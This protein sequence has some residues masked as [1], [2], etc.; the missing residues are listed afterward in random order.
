MEPP[1]WGL[2]AQGLHPSETRSHPP[3]K[4]PHAVAGAGFS[5]VPSSTGNYRKTIFSWAS[6][7]RL[8]PFPKI[9]C[10]KR[11]STAGTVPGHHCTLLLLIGPFF[12]HAATN[13]PTETWKRH[14]TQRISRIILIKT[15]NKSACCKTLTRELEYS[16]MWAIRRDWQNELKI[17]GE[18]RDV[19]TCRETLL[20]H[21]K[22]RPGE[23]KDLALKHPAL[24]GPSSRRDSPPPGNA[25]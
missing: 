15:L 16:S 1:S 4:Q 21:V 18:L 3:A 7:L 23:G 19:K 8:N 17:D 20:N 13:A 24:R 6:S 12:G 22:G 11:M 25:L 10:Q 14:L 2:L 5:V 9:P